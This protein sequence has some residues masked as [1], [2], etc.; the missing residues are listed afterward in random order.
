MST[1]KTD[2]V[3]L[4]IGVVAGLAV[5]CVVMV[6]VGYCCWKKYRTPMDGD[7]LDESDMIEKDSRSS[8]SS[9]HNPFFGSEIAPPVTADPP[10]APRVFVLSD[11]DVEVDDDEEDEEAFENDVQHHNRDVQDDDDDDSDDLFK[12]VRGGGWR[13]PA[14]DDS[15]DD[16]LLNCNITLVRRKSESPKPLRRVSKEHV[17]DELMSKEEMAQF[18]AAMAHLGTAQ[19][20]GSPKRTMTGRKRWN[21]T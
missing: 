16:D 15:D 13:P 18:R 20:G 9:D 11:H 6:I 2:E 14:G 5:G 10:P 4:I 21:A 3:A 19:V 1:L 8:A 17:E 7:D 12:V